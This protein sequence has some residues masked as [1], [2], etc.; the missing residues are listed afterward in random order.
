VPGQAPAWSVEF[1]PTYT[2][3]RRHI[4]E[5]HG[6]KGGEVEAALGTAVLYLHDYHWDNPRASDFYRINGD[7]Y[8]YRF[9]R[10]YLLAFELK[11]ERDQL[12]NPK[13]V[14]LELLTLQ[15]A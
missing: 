11:I 13:R 8:V 9:H 12:G 10:E 3:A 7:L 4:P 2:F 1:N 15:N 5:I 6:I 14:I